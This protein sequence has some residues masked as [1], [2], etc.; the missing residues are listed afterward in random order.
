MWGMARWQAAEYDLP[1]GLQR[2][3][4][5]LAV[6]GPMIAAA[7]MFAI[8]FH[9]LTDAVVG[10]AIGVLLLGGVRVGD[11]LLRRRMPTAGRDTV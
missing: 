7:A 3:F 5:F 6:G 4:G 11:A 2:T 10:A 1:A 9:W 8:N